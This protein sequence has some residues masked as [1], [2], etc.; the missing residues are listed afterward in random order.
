[1][2]RLGGKKKKQEGGEKTKGGTDS[3]NSRKLKRR[4]EGLQVNQKLARNQGE[5]KKTIEKQKKRNRVSKSRTKEG[6]NTS[7]KNDTK[8][9]VGPG[10]GRSFFNAE[11][12]N[13][14]RQ[15]RKRK[16]REE[17]RRAR[18]KKKPNEKK[19]QGGGPEP[20]EGKVGPGKR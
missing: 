9:K 14:G 7:K 10:V 18:A 16:K 5:S 3:L 20:K 8:P 2:K 4:R 13:W 19:I 11:N 15:G 12:K 6:K 17:K 1:V